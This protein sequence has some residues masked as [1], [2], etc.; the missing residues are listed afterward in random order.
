MSTETPT[1]P[2]EVP[3]TILSF[4]RAF[5]SAAKRKKKNYW[6]A[7]AIATLLSIAA[8]LSP[9]AVVAVLLAVLSVVSKA[10]GKLILSAS[11]SLFRVGERQR[12]YDFYMK[13]LAWPSPAADR[14]DTYI[15]NSSPEIKK[16]AQALAP[17][18]ANYYA[19]QGAPGKERLFCNLAE[20]MFWSERL[21]G[22]MASMWWTRFALAAVAVVGVLI[23]T[24]A[25]NLDNEALL[26]VKILSSV[27]ALM[28]TLDVLGEARS[29][30]RGKAEI[31][32]LLGVLEK[33]MARQA[34]S[35]EEALR[36]LVE[37]NC[38]LADLPLIPDA[39]YKS[40]EETLNAAWKE[41]ESSLPFR[42]DVAKGQQG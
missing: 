27:V 7:E 9:V 34:P 28:V 15:A 23:A 1:S 38:L 35:Q 13:A 4:S 40:K 14:A 37:Y 31:G 39:L 26:V 21:F 20:S 36:L 3:P 18:E 16:A 5:L 42:C 6:R 24:I 25:L 19:H 33:E 10:I 30:D 8:S 29:S 41:Y 12:R 11:K 17:R 2:D 22:A 32:K